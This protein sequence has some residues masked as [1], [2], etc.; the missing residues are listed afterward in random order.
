MLEALILVVFP[1][2]M[3]MAAMTDILTMTIPNRVSL[4][5]AV[6]YFVLAPLVG[7]DFVTIGWSV[8][9]AMCVFAVCFALFALNVMGGGD[10]KILTASALWFGFGLDLVDYLTL[11]AYLGAFLTIGILVLRMKMLSHILDVLP[12]PSHLVDPKGGVPYG[13]AIGMAALL[14]YPETKIFILALNG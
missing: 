2:C 3:A 1:L 13:V 8:V 10:A 11:V 5:L 7:L 14:N 4:L 12:I 6:S 9:A